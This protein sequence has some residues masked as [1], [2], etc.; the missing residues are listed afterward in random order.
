M[1]ETF[2]LAFARQHC[3]PRSTTRYQ[4]L[5]HQRQQATAYNLLHHQQ[6]SNSRYSRLTISYLSSLCYTCMV[7]P[8][9]GSRRF[10]GTGVHHIH[11]AGFNHLRQYPIW[12]VLIVSFVTFC[13][14]W[15]GRVSR[16]AAY[17][18]FNIDSLFVD[19]YLT[20]F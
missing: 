1:V 10:H 7:I 8:K 11:V 15:G 2:C 9:S 4:R 6:P 17:L 16:H 12:H 13:S 19:R 3:S 5:L 20:T 18:I 14:V